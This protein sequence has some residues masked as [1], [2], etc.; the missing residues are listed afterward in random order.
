MVGARGVDWR[1]RLAR[2]LFLG[3]LRTLSRPP[4]GGGTERLL[5]RLP[6]Q[7]HLGAEFDECEIIN[8]GCLRAAT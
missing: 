2:G 4:K 1:Q 7:M 8:N 5:L 3:L 6:S